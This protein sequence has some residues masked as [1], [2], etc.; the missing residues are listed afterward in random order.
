MARTLGTHQINIRI[1]KTI[2]STIPRNQTLPKSGHHFP[3]E[4]IRSKL[5]SQF[6]Y[7]LY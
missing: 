3:R 2:A 4:Q 6:A 5:E 1:Y 7:E